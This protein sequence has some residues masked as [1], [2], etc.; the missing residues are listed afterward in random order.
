MQPQT[1]EE[2]LTRFLMRYDNPSTIRVYRRL[3][4][5]FVGYFGPRTPLAAISPEHLD[6]WHYLMR[7]GLAVA[8]I[9]SRVRHMKAFWNWCVRREYIP[10]SPARFLEYI[11]QDLAFGS[12]ALP[13]DTLDRIFEAATDRA[14]EFLRLRDSAILALIITYGARAGD[15]ASLRLSRINFDEGVLILYGKGRKDNAL[16]I[17]H[18]AGVLL[19]QW[20]DYRRGL[21]PDPDHDYCFVTIRTRP[22][23][24]YQPLTSAGIQVM[25]RRLSK[26]VSDGSYGPHSARHLRAKLNTLAGVPEH[27][28][29][30]VLNH[31]DPSITRQYARL[32][33]RDARAVLEKLE[34]QRPLLRKNKSAGDTTDPAFWRKKSG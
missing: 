19:R 26:A 10:K 6:E 5:E 28:T 30:M 33:L 18:D 4:G 20:V 11:R 17:P 14:N 32:D 25:F 21:D 9:N 1:L 8:T 27:L 7:D 2:A 3:L 22:G 29:Q 24:R 13:V 16:P 31:S 12:K 23:E 15:V 34:Q